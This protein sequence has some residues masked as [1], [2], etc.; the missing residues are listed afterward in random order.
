LYG[1]LHGQ[2]PLQTRNRLDMQDTA[3]T[4]AID[5][6]LHTI[7][8]KATLGDGAGK[9]ILD[10]GCGTGCWTVRAAKAFPNAQVTGL[11]IVKVQPADPLPSNVAFVEHDILQP[12]D[13]MK[14]PPASFDVI[15]CR[16][17]G[18]IVSHMIVEP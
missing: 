18:S 1:P 11:D 15:H 14:L 17:L 4:L 8:L 5:G 9:H 13:N 12:F 2:L 10:V 7:D 6:K 3:W 16:F